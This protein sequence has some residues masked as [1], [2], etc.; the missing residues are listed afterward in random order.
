MVTRNRM[1]RYRVKKA[2]N[3]ELNFVIESDENGNEINQHPIKGL[4]IAKKWA[5]NRKKMFGP[6]RIVT[7]EKVLYV[8]D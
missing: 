7:I 1:K 3:H 6:K 5:L 4:E 8:V 2:S